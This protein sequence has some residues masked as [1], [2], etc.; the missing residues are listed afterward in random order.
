VGEHEAAVDADRAAHDLARH[1]SDIALQAIADQ[2]LGQAY[3]ALGDCPRL[4]AL[5]RAVASLQGDL[6]RRPVGMPSLP[7]VFARTWLVWCPGERT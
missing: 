3:H 2:Y 4:A 5:R 7:A 1:A 6:V